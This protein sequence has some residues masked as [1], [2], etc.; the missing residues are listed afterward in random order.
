MLRGSGGAAGA[1]PLSAYDLVRLSA[2]FGAVE[3]NPGVRDEFLLGGKREV[4]VLGTGDGA[5]LNAC[6]ERQRVGA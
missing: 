3:L 4:Q 5:L 2:A 1:P 6:S